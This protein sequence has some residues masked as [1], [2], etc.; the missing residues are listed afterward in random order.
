MRGPRSSLIPSPAGVTIPPRVGVTPEYILA[1]TPGEAN[2]TNVETQYAEA[3][4][5]ARKIS[6]FGV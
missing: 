2:L 4:R 6:L 3:K 1:A 5:A